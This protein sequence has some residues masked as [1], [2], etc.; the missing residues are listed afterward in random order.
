MTSKCKSLHLY[1]EIFPGREISG[2]AAKPLFD[3]AHLR[4]LTSKP[5]PNPPVRRN[6]RSTIPSHQS[7]CR[8]RRK[9]ADCADL[10][11]VA[12][13]R[14]DVATRSITF[15]LSFGGA[16]R[17]NGELPRRRACDV[18]RWPPGDPRTTRLSPPPH[19][20]PIVSHCPPYI[21]T[22]TFTSLC[23]GVHHLRKAQKVLHRFRIVTTQ[24]D[25]AGKVDIGLHWSDFVIT[26]IFRQRINY[27]TSRYVNP[28][29]SMRRKRKGMVSLSSI[30]SLFT[31]LDIN[32]ETGIV[33]KRR[34]SLTG[35]AV[36]LNK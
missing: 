3:L 6:T 30:M 15:L 1:L 19:P 17:R 13:S 22:T 27:A 9:A 36:G 8:R 18:R 26:V 11:D 14:R 33:I 34:I 12:F 31:L 4:P 25:V 23:R 29:I 32:H 28:W 20:A 10:S 35:L 7:H 21:R 5:V 24:V 16:A 2:P